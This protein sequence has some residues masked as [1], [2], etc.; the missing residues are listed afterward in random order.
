MKINLKLKI[1]KSLFEYSN[2][3]INFQLDGKYLL[4][5]KEDNFF[6]KFKGNKNNFEFYSLLDLDNS[7]F[8]N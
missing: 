6:I 1:Q 7:I 3:L 8:K 5:N 2:D 4:K